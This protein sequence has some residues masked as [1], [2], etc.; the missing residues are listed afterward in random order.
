MDAT[1]ESIELEEHVEE[2][3]TEQTTQLPEHPPPTTSA[4]NGNGMFLSY[5]GFRLEGLTPSQLNS[6]NTKNCH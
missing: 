2:M 1:N 4:P 6:S 3:P 5:C